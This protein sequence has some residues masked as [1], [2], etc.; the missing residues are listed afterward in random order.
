MKII[1]FLTSHF[2]P[3]NTACTNRVLSLVKELEK[4]MKVNVICLTEKGLPT[5]TPIVKYSENTTIY[6]VNQYD[7]DGKNFFNRAFKEIH[8]IR[9]LVSLSNRIPHN[10]LIATAPYMFMIP[11]VGYFAKGAK[12]IDIRDLVWEYLDENSPVKKIIKQTLRSIML[13]GMRRFNKIT[14]TNHYEFQ[15]LTQ[16]EGFDNV[17]VVANG[18]SQSSYEKLCSIVPNRDIPFTIT[19]VGNIGIAQD[20]KTLLEAARRL[21]NVKFNIIGD[22]IEL[23]HLQE[24][25]REHA[26]ENV[27]FT[28]KLPWNELETYYQNSSVLYAHLDKKFVSAMPSKLYE[29]ASVGLPIIYGGIGQA[30]SFIERLENAV[31]IEPNNADALVDAINQTMTFNQTLSEN[32]REFI[33]LNCLREGSVKI[34]DDI[35]QSLLIHT[36]KEHT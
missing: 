29:Y 10:I 17:A 11:I 20:L 32:N 30:V 14:V 26:I 21:K 31:A 35:V 6:Y 5:D 24:Y 33:R 1:N 13:S 36:S 25:A 2:V 28:G 3:E 12:I 18:I 9:Q 7:F 27:T 22:G 19:Y 16:H 15:V 8:Y 23:P 34:V 4:N